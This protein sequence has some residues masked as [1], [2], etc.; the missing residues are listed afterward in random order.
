M[1]HTMKLPEGD[2]TSKAFRTHHEMVVVTVPEGMT[3][4][5]F[6]TLDFTGESM[7]IAGPKEIEIQTVMDEWSV[8]IRKAVEMKT[9]AKTLDNQS[10]IGFWELEKRTAREDIKFT[11]DCGL[12]GT[13]EKSDLYKKSITTQMTTLA[14]EGTLT[15]VDFIKGT[16][17]PLD[18]KTT[19]QV[20]KLSHMDLTGLRQSASI[21]CPSVSGK[22]TSIYVWA[23]KTTTS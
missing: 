4:T 15:F 1:K 5:L 17:T 11:I 13:D 14:K 22:A 6:K 2:Y 7:A 16:K 23:M 10:V 8:Q 19:S 21:W 3:A 18:A 20:Y 9:E 12:T